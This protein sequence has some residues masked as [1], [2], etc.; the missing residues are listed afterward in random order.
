MANNP[1]ELIKTEHLL[2]I[3]NGKNYP[4]WYGRTK[5]QL[6]G[7]DLWSVCITP[8]AEP[9]TLAISAAPI[10]TTSSDHTISIIVP[11]LSQR[12]Y[13]ECV[14]NTTSDS[15]YLLWKKIAYQY[16]SRTVINQ[17]Q[18]YMTWSALVYKGDLQDYID[19]TRA[20]LID[21]DAVGINV[22]LK[23]IAYLI[24]GKIMNQDL[25]QII[26]KLALDEKVNSNPYMVLNELHP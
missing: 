10:S 26:D 16:T 6:R 24:L 4:S 21:I 14:N 22:L 12:C 5:V 17:G 7:K 19:D 13:N 20:C 9:S 25:D 2:P 11:R 15:A 23:V 18:V 3:L 8:P 1:S